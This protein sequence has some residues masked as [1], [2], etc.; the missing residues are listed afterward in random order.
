MTT[1]KNLKSIL[2]LEINRLHEMA[3]S[4]PLKGEEVKKLESLTRAW[5]T[6]NATQEQ[7]NEAGG[8]TLTDEELLAIA[9]AVAEDE[10]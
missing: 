4:E 3:L 7:P 8:S 9:K 1:S 10:A 6:Y 5:K 2:E